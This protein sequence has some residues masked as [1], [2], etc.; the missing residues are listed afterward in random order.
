MESNDSPEIPDRGETSD[1]PGLPSRGTKWRSRDTGR[2]GEDQTPWKCSV[3]V[4]GH[5]QTMEKIKPFGNAQFKSRDTNRLWTKWTLGKA[6][7]NYYSSP[8]PVFQQKQNLV[9]IL[10]L[11]I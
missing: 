10:I 2:H 1:I 9:Y 3:Q 11:R 7:F 4:Q 6:Q 8:L 5:K